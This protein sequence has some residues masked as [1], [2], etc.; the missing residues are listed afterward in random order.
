MAPVMTALLAQYSLAPARDALA[1]LLGV[2]V[3]DG[4]GAAARELRALLAPKA[5]APKATVAP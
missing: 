5:L 4:A 1:G 2:P 3:L